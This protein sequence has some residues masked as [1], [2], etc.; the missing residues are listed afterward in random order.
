MNKKCAIYVL[1]VIVISPRST[2]KLGTGQKIR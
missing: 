2:G 1:K